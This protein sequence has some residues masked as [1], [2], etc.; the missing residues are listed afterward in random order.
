MNFKKVI[1]NLFSVLFSTECR[2]NSEF[3]FSQNELNEIISNSKKENL[4]YF[5]S[6]SNI[7]QL[8]AFDLSYLMSNVTLDEKK[9][10]IIKHACRLFNEKE[11]QSLGQTY[12]DFIFRVSA[13]IN[14]LNDDNLD[15]FKELVQC[16]NELYDFAYALKNPLRVLNKK[17]DK[18]FSYAFEN[19]FA[20]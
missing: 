17:C 13:N 12:S 1:T 20:E 11:F 10:S 8:S 14:Y 5:K 18:S 4:K 16:K 6:L 3:R 2:I 19:V 15:L 7:K 9:I